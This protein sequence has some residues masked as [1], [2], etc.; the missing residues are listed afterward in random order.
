MYNLWGRA[1]LLREVDAIISA[2]GAGLAH[3]V[4][5]RQPRLFSCLSLRFHCA[6]VSAGRSPTKRCL[7]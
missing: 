7:S 4:S 3:G 6:V 5:A 1:G 2:Q